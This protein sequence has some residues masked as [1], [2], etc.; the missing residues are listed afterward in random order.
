MDIDAQSIR[1]I[2]QFQ[3]GLKNHSLIKEDISH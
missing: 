2:G 3:K 1:T